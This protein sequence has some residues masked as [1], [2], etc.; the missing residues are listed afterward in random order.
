MVPTRGAHEAVPSRSLHSP[1]P[2]THCQNPQLPPDSGAAHAVLLGIRG[3][4]VDQARPGYITRSSLAS[5][6]NLLA[7][8]LC[9]P[10]VDRERECSERERAVS[11]AEG[12]PPWIVGY[13]VARALILSP[14]DWAAHEEAVRGCNRGVVPWDSGNCSPSRLVHRGPH[15]LRGQPSCVCHLR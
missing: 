4:A 15:L 8:P 3:P 1:H 2:G 7:P 12:A 14:E 5:C 9:N 11:V 6:S 10:S 13:S